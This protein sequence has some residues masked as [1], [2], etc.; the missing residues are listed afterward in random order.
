[1]IFSRDWI[2]YIAIIVTRTS[3]KN[4]I[5]KIPIFYKNEPSF[6]ELDLPPLPFFCQSYHQYHHYHLRSFKDYFLSVLVEGSCFG[7]FNVSI[8]Q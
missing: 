5:V 2:S 3:F 7:A 8:P 4:L 6:V 1:M